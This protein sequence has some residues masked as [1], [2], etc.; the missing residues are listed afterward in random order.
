MDTKDL[1]TISDVAKHYGISRV[2]VYDA[3]NGGKLTAIEVLGQRVVKR[4]ELVKFTPRAY[5]DRERAVLPPDTVPE[6]KRP[7]GR[8]R[9]Q[10]EPIN[11]QP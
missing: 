5:R 3:I 8:P 6:P 9:K 7:R 4:T 10:K 2:A 11:E 1:L